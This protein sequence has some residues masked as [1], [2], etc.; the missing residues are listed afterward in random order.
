MCVSSQNLPNSQTHLKRRKITKDKE[1]KRK[2]EPE[3]KK[4]K[5]IRLERKS[6]GER[7]N[8]SFLFYS[9]F[10]LCSSNY[11]ISLFF[12]SRMNEVLLLLLSIILK[13]FIILKLCIYI[14]SSIRVKYIKD[15]WVYIL[16]CTILESMNLRFYFLK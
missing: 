7:K 2:K 13:G 4:I 14:N 12:F 16:Y 11:F 10:F 1:R 6:F 3:L 9:F 5:K 8:A 15:D